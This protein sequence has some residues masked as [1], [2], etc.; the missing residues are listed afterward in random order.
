MLRGLKLGPCRGCGCG[1][2]ELGIS[3]HH[4]VPKSLGGDDV[5]DNVIPLCGHG[6]LGCHGAVEDHPRG[7]EEIAGRIRASLTKA[8]I[9]YVVLKKS[10]DFLDRYYPQTKEETC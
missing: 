3:L 5:A 1:T 2:T 7:W 6:T 8:E 10:R 9:G 4:L